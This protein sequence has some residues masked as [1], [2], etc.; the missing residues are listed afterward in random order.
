MFDF[1]IFLAFVSLGLA[2]VYWKLW[3]TNMVIPPGAEKPL[4]VRD[5]LRFALDNGLPIKTDFG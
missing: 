2:F 1:L 3:R 5:R 4:P